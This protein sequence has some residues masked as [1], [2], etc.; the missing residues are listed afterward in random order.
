MLSLNST[1]IRSGIAEQNEHGHQTS[2]SHLT[3]QLKDPN[4]YQTFVVLF[5]KTHLPKV[6]NLSPPNPEAGEG[7]D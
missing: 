4:C 7:E 3:C 6:S 1:S 2:E 5:S